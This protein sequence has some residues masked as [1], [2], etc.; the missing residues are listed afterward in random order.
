MW[1]WYLNELVFC[2]VVTSS[3]TPVNSGSTANTTVST[4][5][6]WYLDMCKVPN[7]NTINLANANLT[8]HN[9]CHLLSELLQVSVCMLSSYRTHLTSI[10]DFMNTSCMHYDP[11]PTI[12]AL[13]ARAVYSMKSSRHYF[14]WRPCLLSWNRS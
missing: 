3:T 6:S 12:L 13:A 10:S 9:K 11:L 2:F 7:F 14:S 1:N 4:W 5:C 8:S